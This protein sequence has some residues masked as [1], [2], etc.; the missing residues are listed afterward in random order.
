MSRTSEAEIHPQ[1]MGRWSPRSF[2]ETP[3]E[4]GHLQAVFEAA[5]WAPSAFN[6][7]PWRFLYATQPADLA[8]FRGLLSAWNQGWANKAPVLGFVVGQRRFAHNDTPNG[9]AGF[10][11][12]AAWMSLA[13]QAQL[14]GL[15]THAMAGV[16]FDAAYGVLGVD[17]ADYEILCAFVLGHRGPPDQVPEGTEDAPNA[18]RPVSET[19]FEGVWRG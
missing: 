8:R 9:Y 18:R 14:L 17:R 2:A 10:D 1:F 16:D 7:Q 3:V 4:P 6:A 13:L 19:A 15:A 12:G 11:S 5:R